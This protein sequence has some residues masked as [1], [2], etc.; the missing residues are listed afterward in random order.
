[1]PIVY[2]T[3]D[4]V[5]FKV[6]GENITLKKRLGLIHMQSFKIAINLDIYKILVANYARYCD[7]YFTICLI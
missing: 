5:W 4:F 2:L 7:K 1:M 6:K 3:M